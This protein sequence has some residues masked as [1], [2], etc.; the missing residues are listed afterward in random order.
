MVR[1]QPFRTAKTAAHL[2]SMDAMKLLIWYYPALTLS[3]RSSS[4]PL[5][6]T[7]RED[8]RV[9]D[10]LEYLHAAKA[11]YIYKHPCL[12]RDSNPVPTAQQS[13]SLTT[14]PDAVAQGA[15]G[16]R[17]LATPKHF[18]YHTPNRT[19]SRPRAAPD[20]NHPAPNL[21]IQ[22]PTSGPMVCCCQ[23][24]HIISPRTHRSP[25]RSTPRTV[26][27]EIPRPAAKR[28]FESASHWVFP[29]DK[30]PTGLI[31]HHLLWQQVDDV[32]QAN[33]EYVTFRGTDSTA[34][35]RHFSSLQQTSSQNNSQKAEFQHRHTTK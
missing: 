1:G 10:Y 33:A 9:D 15:S 25:A 29:P 18:R 12:F 19:A 32:V 22:Q 2:F 8:L 6:P 26:R 7:S 14:I 30:L 17:P 21:D 3:L 16:P 5:P 23:R 4:L 35:Q 13:A 28:N 31:V 34:P 11:L 20:P 27:P 24:T